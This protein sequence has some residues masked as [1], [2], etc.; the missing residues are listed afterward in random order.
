[1]KQAQAD[2]RAVALRGKAAMLH[3]RFAVTLAVLAAIAGV[4]GL[5]LVLRPTPGALAG[6]TVP[7]R[8]PDLR[9]QLPSELSIRAVKAKDGGRRRYHL[10]FRS[11]VDNVGEGALII[12]ADRPSLRIREMVADQVV[13]R[14]GA[15][16]RRI[17]RVGRL[18]YV[19]ADTHQH[20]HLLD[21][22]RYELRTADD[23]HHRVVRDRKSGFCLGDRLR[24]AGVRGARRPLFSFS[25][26]GS[27]A[28]GLLAVR[29]GISPGWGDDYDPQREGQYLD[30]TTVPAGRYR[31]VHRANPYRQLREATLAN[32]PPSLLIDLSRPRGP[33][34]LPRVHVVA[35]CPATDR[36]TAR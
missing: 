7:E 24:V 28:P 27:L 9:Q 6:G 2:C 14:R 4:A 33:S 30:I 32:N 19:Q 29:E 5:A 31:L 16:P 3:P 34:G 1:M 17:A 18:R 12:E 11:A 26:C 8:L 22:D 10:G 36:C 13:H 15:L 21:F 23:A 20:W 35:S 25:E